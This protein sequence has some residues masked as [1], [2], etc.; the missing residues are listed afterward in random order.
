MRK[1]KLSI[2]DEQR[3]AQE[4]QDI[5]AVFTGSDK[6]TAKLLRD[7]VDL[8]A[9]TLPEDRVSPDR[10]WCR[11]FFLEDFMT[12][13][14]EDDF[15]LIARDFMQHEYCNFPKYEDVV[16][17]EDTSPSDWPEMQ[18]CNF[19]LNKML[20][21]ALS[22][23][24]YARSLILYLHKIYYR[25]EYKALKRFSSMTPGELMA[26]AAP[27][28]EDE[29]MINNLARVLCIAELSGIKLHPDVDLTF[30][31]LNVIGENTPH[32][33]THD[34]PRAEERYAD[35]IKEIEGHFDI[36]RFDCMVNEES[37]F[38]RNALRSFG[39]DPDYADLCDEHDYTLLELLGRTLAILQV[40]YPE[41]SFTDSD[42]A[43]YASILHCAGALAGNADMNIA[44]RNSLT[45]TD[46]VFWAN[47]PKKTYL[48]KPE[49]VMSAALTPAAANKPRAEK[50]TVPLKEEKAEP[51][52]SEEALIK[53]IEALRAS[54]R[55]LEN[56]AKDLQGELAG[57]KKQEEEKKALQDAVE[58]SNK[59]LSALRSYVYS[60][61]DDESV[62]KVS[63]AE[64]RAAISDLKIIIVG[65]HIN[66]V[67]KLKREFPKWTFVNPEASGSTNVDIV[68]KADHV[69]FFT[70]TISHS[71]YYQF[72]NVLR[73]RKIKFGY[74]H[75]V[76]IE[77]NIADVYNGIKGED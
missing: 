40:T 21:A 29:S 33:A 48:F 23:S 58:A 19:I 74:I 3:R 22:G 38:L 56:E 14:M 41:R 2:G 26:L 20:N 13:E 5:Y 28:D 31:I 52:Y 54:V 35:C 59:E 66:W 10:Y 67:S 43:L 12:E 34:L 24:E 73:E 72:L 8:F 62:P 39:Y 50:K 32:P 51:R 53:E 11:S 42:L 18:F 45:I 77:K 76:N 30:I 36:D 47:A 71:R 63:V 60:L 75:G 27:G 37:R 44:I 4:L 64:M 69:F 68:N 55:R 49:E 65:G 17:I 7:Q 57:K 9:H 16:Y 6:P 46:D 15:P 1:I 61:S 70:D 25:K